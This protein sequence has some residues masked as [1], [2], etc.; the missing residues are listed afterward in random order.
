[1][2]TG[3]SH[4]KATAARVGG[5]GT[6]FDDYEYSEEPCRCTIGEDHDDTGATVSSYDLE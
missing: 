4:Y 6:N 3:A 5:D 2:P 1:M